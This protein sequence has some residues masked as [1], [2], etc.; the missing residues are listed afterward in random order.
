MSFACLSSSSCSY[1]PCPNQFQLLANRATRHRNSTLWKSLLLPFGSCSNSLIW[2]CWPSLARNCRLY[3]S[4][5]RNVIDDKSIQVK[6]VARIRPQRFISLNF[7]NLLRASRDLTVSFTYLRHIMSLWWNVSCVSVPAFA[8]SFP[9]ESH[10]PRPL[11][12]KLSGRDVGSPAASKKSFWIPTLWLQSN[13]WTPASVQPSK[14]QGTPS[15]GVTKSHRPWVAWVL[16][17]YKWTFWQSILQEKYLLH[18]RLWGA[19]TQNW[20]PVE[21][22]IGKGSSSGN[23]W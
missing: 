2:S 20:M 18:L 10:L 14:L 22:E 16:L 8:L 19:S 21:C 7:H 3:A 23:M 11:S 12:K 4:K 5:A 9:P 13:T 6:F 1:R 17:P 15:A